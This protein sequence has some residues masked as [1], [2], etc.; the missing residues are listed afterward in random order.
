MSLKEFTARCSA[1]SLITAA[2][3]GIAQAAEPA[4]RRSAP[5]A[6][7]TQQ[8]PSSDSGISERVNAALT[9]NKITGVQIQTEQGVVT[10]AGT[11]ASEEIRQK[12]ARIAAAVDG[13]HVVD[14]ASL[15]IKRGA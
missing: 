4:P 15:K 3:F 1:I 11:V 12:A 13:V 5:E 10:L 8:S 2:A 7:V 14:I 9:A 6:P